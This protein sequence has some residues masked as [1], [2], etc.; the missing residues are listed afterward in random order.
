MTDEELNAE[1]LKLICEE[2][3]EKDQEPEQTDEQM[4]DDMEDLI[5]S[6]E[7]TLFWGV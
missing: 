3:M 6:G 2:N 1:F 7:T 5:H 4:T